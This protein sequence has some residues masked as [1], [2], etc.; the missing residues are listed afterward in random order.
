LRTSGENKSTIGFKES[1][2]RSK[3]PLETA[4]TLL[5]LPPETL[6]SAARDLGISAEGWEVPGAEGIRGIEM[7]CVVRKEARSDGTGF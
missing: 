4:S 2:K 6:T 7:G 3:R 5:P 1:N